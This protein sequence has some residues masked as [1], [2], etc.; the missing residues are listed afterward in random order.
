[1]YSFHEKMLS[2]GYAM[3]KSISKRVENE[4]FQMVIV[5]QEGG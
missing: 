1:M 4:K 5:L 3:L 2:N